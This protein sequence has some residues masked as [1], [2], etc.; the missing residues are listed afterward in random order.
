MPKVIKPI[1]CFT[2]DETEAQRLATQFADSRA[3]TSRPGTLAF[4]TLV[5]QHGAGEFK[6][7]YVPCH[8]MGTFKPPV[9]GEVRYT[10]K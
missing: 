10:Y 9:G 4:H 3:M 6:F 2:R 1:T 8:L 7:L 5:A